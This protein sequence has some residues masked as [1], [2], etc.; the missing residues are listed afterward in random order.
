MLRVMDMGRAS[1]Y[2]LLP[3]YAMY[4]I[5]YKG[6]KKWYENCIYKEETMPRKGENIRKRK[7]GR[8]EARYIKARDVNGKIR[9]G[10]LYG[11]TYREVKAKKIISFPKFNSMFHKTAITAALLPTPHSARHHNG[12]NFRFVIQ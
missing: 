7:D 1:L 5:T 9:Y 8:W 10:Y 2:P 11:R 6:S 3:Q 4:Y 12:G